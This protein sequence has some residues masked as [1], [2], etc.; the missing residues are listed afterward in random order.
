MRKYFEFYNGT[1]IKCGDSALQ[2]I[3]EELFRLGVKRPI[4]LSSASG[5]R[6]GTTDKLRAA[7]AGAHID[8]FIP[9]DGIPAVT[10]SEL[11]RKIKKTYLASECD[12][13]IALGGDSVMDSA[14][15]LKLFL[16]QDCDEILPIAG[17][18]EQKG[19]SAPLLAI[20]TENGSGKEATGSLELE[21]VYL[22]TNAILPEVVI[23]DED[24]ATA[25]PSRT[26]AA[27][28][29]Y[30]LANAIE[31]YIGAEP[32]DLSGIYAEKAIRLLSANLEKAVL[33]GD[34]EE[35]CRSTAL[36][37]TLAGIAYGNVPFGAAH[38]LAEGLA[39]ICGEPI[40]EMYC[41]VLPAALKY[42][43]NNFDDRIKELLFHLCGA[44]TYA[45][46]PDSER[47]NKAIAEVASL[48][49]RLRKSANIPTK[50]SETQITRESFGLIAEAASNRRSAI[51]AFTPITKE[52]FLSVLND[53]Y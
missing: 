4:L 7:L 9:Y 42:A 25:A 17:A 20:P 34:D 39:E 28:G 12:G 16:S 18:M 31:A 45:E 35:A 51:T 22:A 30:A 8:G 26:V 3:G 44:N 52:D 38:A 41:I 27:C 53:A 11:V 37:G 6:L 15:C 40:E 14:K 47:A 23:I 5:D 2:T 43:R 29:V 21:G 46:T 36:A 48:I 13:I 33:D 32:E 50:I 24:V 1:K 10:D 19:K 49:E